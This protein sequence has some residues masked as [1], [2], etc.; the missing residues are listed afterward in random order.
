MTVRTT[1]VEAMLAVGTRLLNLRDR[2]LAHSHSLRYLITSS[3][4]LVLVVLWTAIHLESGN[5]LEAAEARTRTDLSN[6]ALA[7]EAD[8]MR[9]IDRA[10]QVIRFVRR[11]A[12][13]QGPAL[14]LGDRGLKSAILDEGYTLVSVVG[15][16]GMITHSTLQV[17]HVDL[18]DRPHFQFH[19]QHP[20]DVLNISTPVLGRATKKWSLQLTRRIDDAQGRFAGMVAVSIDPGFFT[21][22]FE[23]MTLG[24]DAV[25]TLTGADGIVR[26]RRDAHGDER[27]GQSV[28]AS[29]VTA[30][31]RAQGTGTAWAESGVDGHRRLWAFRTLPQHGLV[32]VIGVAESQ[33]F[34]R[35]RQ[36][37]IWL[38]ALGA[39][40]TAAVAVLTLTLLASARRKTDLVL[41][42]RRRGDVTDGINRA[43][44]KILLTVSHEL[45]TPL[46]GIL[47]YADLVREYPKDP[48]IREHGEVICACAR[49]LHL[50]ISNMIDLA[51]MESGQLRCKLD[52]APWPNPLTEELRKF[53]SAAS[54]KGL[55]LELHVGKH[56]PRTIWTDLPRLRRVLESLLDNA[57]KF[58]ANGRVR[59]DLLHVDNQARIVISDTGPGIAADRLGTIFDRFHSGE[60][61]CSGPELGA[62]LGLPLA[63]GLTELIGGTLVVEST[64]GEGTR[65]IINL[66]IQASI[67]DLVLPP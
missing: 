38:L 24:S 23:N 14:D 27:A 9:T 39:G 20:V 50:L 60:P 32:A 25:V 49:R 5:M 29:P 34:E 16:D 58:T 53:Q 15:A 59:I 1:A 36:Q 67:P 45:R 8:A 13:R 12:H 62:G 4:A 63:R 11:E 33:V 2:L 61:D 47:G 48:Q 51:Q 21:R 42:L 3:A 22:F 46:H 52:D 6:L 56:C 41:Q 66:P 54:A 30:A 44:R 43:T 26:A 35:A 7:F 31:I 10:D 17:S 40:L 28:N 19:R 65:A 37:R 18:S 64:V 57:V 55:S